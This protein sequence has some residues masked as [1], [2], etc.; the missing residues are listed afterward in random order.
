[1]AHDTKYLSEDE[2]QKQLAQLEKTPRNKEESIVEITLEYR[3][4]SPL[5]KIEVGII[6]QE[7]LGH[8]IERPVL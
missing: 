7:E 5:G 3:V 2:Q 6:T 8:N 4:E 1:M